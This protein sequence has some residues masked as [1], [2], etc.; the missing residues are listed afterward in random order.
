MLYRNIMMLLFFIYGN[1]LYS[2]VNEV[3]P[4]DYEAP[5]VDM[6]LVTLYLSEKKM[7]GPYAQGEKL[8]ED[9]VTSRISA[10]KLTSTFTI[11]GYTVCPHGRSSVFGDQK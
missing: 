11:K 7:V 9:H 2:A 6:N 1:T 4:G 8:T 10:L 3:I 5:R